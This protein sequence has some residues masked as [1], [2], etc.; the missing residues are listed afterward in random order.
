LDRTD[1]EYMEKVLDKLR[2]ITMTTAQ[3]DWVATLNS[4]HFESK[5]IKLIDLYHFQTA[6][7]LVPFNLQATVK[8][9]RFGNEKAAQKLHG[10][11]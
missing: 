6:P 10:F 4:L 5:V 9:K 7:A 2:F 1:E 8:F 3:P 11:S